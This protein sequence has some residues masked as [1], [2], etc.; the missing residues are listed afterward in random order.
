MIL[1][2]KYIYLSGVEKKI[3]VLQSLHHFINERLQ[4]IIE[5]NQD[6]KQDLLLSLDSVPLLIDIIITL[7]K[8]KYKINK[9]TVINKDYSNDDDYNYN[10]NYNYNNNKSR[11]SCFNIFKKQIKHKKNEYDF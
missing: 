11:F 3:I 5:L 8:G 4:Y 9:K 10:Y 2:D 1:V 6:K 7:Q